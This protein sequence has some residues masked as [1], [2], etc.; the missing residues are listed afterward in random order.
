MQ[1]IIASFLTFKM[2][3]VNNIQY[4]SCLY[5]TQL[6]VIYMLIHVVFTFIGEKFMFHSK[7]Q[8]NR[9]K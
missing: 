9:Q 5:F 4:L 1:I 2:L 3:L 8:N 6:I 7:N